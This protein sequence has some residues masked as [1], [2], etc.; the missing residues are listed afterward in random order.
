MNS[1]LSAPGFG[2]ALQL[3]TG[4]LL[5]VVAY[6]MGHDHFAL[7]RSGTRAQGRVVATKTISQRTGSSSGF[8]HSAPHA[9]VEFR[10][11]DRDVQFVDWLNVRRGESKG[12]LVPIIYDSARPDV[13]MI[14]RP[15]WNWFPWGGIAAVGA[16]LIVSAAVGLVRRPRSSD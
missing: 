9:V 4:V 3:G 5:A 1:S 13:A 2:R 16:L 12:S 7:I 11:G 15:A 10:A 8:S 6:M 14:D